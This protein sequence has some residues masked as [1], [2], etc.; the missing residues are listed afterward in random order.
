MTLLLNCPQVVLRCESDLNKS[1]TYNFPQ[2]S[3]YFFG[4]K[5]YCT[6]KP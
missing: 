5:N 2:Q 4:H 3:L 1:K 6:L